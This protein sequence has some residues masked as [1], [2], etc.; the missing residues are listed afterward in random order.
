MYNDTIVLVCNIVSFA[1]IGPIEWTVPNAEAF[2]QVGINDGVSV[3]NSTL[4]IEY[5]TIDSRGLYSCNTSNG[6]GNG[7]DVQDISVIG[8]LV[9]M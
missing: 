4:T 1:P 6:V 8:E 3:Y 7:G 9:Y 5:A 2:T